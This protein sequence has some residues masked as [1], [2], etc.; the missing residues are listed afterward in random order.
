MQNRKSPG[1]CGSGAFIYTER[2]TAMLSKVRRFI[3]QE[4]L[5]QAGETVVVGVSG[6]ADSICLLTMLAELSGE[7]EIRLEAVHVNHGIRGAEADRDEAFVRKYC[8]SL[9]IP[10]HGFSCDV[11]MIAKE[12]HLTEEEAGRMVRRESFQKVMEE[13]GSRITAVAHNLNDNAETVLFHLLRGSGLKGLSGMEAKTGFGPERMLIRPLLSSS[14]EEIE[15]WLEA[16]KIPFCRDSTNESVEYSRNRIRKRIMPEAE[17]INREAAVHIVRAAALLGEIGQEEEQQAKAWLE[18]HGAVH[19]AEQMSLPAKELERLSHVRAGL[20]IRAAVSRLT[21]SLKDLT[22]RHTDSV[23]GLL[24][25]QTGRQVMLPG[26]LTA[27]REYE[28][29]VIGR[30]VPEK[31]KTEAANGVEYAET[32]GRETEHQGSKGTDDQADPEKSE[33]FLPE[34]DGAPVTVCA[35]GWRLT[36]RVSMRQPGQKIPENRYT[37]WFDYDKI[38]NRLS[39]RKRRPGD[40]FQAFSDGRKQTVK[41]YMVNEKIPAVLRDQIPLLAEEDHVLWIT[42]GR[43]SEAYKVTETTVRVLEAAVTKE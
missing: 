37:K 6:G 28:Q 25:K 2:N 26:G 14:R 12:Q 40:W 3:A 7:L 39:F 10:F 15:E 4:Q 18:R 30:T 21:G 31:R 19:A 41:A 36:C 35:E 8:E 20:V 38:K 16:R 34:P 5:L 27:R 33:W 13:T 32:G 1:D 42:G 11:P 22:M 29:I 43:I 24:E 9:K 23:L 17:I